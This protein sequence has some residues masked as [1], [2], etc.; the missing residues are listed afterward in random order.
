LVT[1]LAVLVPVLTSQL[2]RIRLPIVVG[3]IVAGMIIGESGLGLVHPTPILSFLAEFGFTFLMLLSGLEVNFETLSGGAQGLEQRPLRQRPIPLA[4]GY[5]GLTVL[6]A[7]GIGFGLAA[8]GLTRNP[9]LMG[10]ILST[11][12]LGIVVPILKERRLTAGVYGQAVLVAALVSDFVTLLLLSLTIAIIGKGLSLDLLLFMLLLAIF[13]AAAKI[14]PWMT[15]RPMLRRLAEEL[16]HATAQI[17]VRGAFALMVIWAVLADALGVE[18]ILG[19]FLA[20]AILNV[21][22]RS[23]ESNLH[24]TLDAIGYGALVMVPA[25]GL[26]GTETHHGQ[27]TEFVPLTMTGAF[28]SRGKWPVR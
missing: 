16:S 20:G 3:E 19:A 7:T 22:S 15:S 21:S 11:T 12:S 27:L 13:A 2:R 24:E 9:I 18:I 14:G 6:L 1:I 4:L 10:L 17:H 26:R 8:W 5:F 28:R 23:G 25:T